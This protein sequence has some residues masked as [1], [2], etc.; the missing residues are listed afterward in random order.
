MF[1]PA[2]FPNN[3]TNWGTS[4]QIC[5]PMKVCFSFKPPPRILGVTLASLSSLPTAQHLRTVFRLLS[6]HIFI[7]FSS[8]NVLPCM[9]VCSLGV[10]LVPV[11][12]RREYQ[13][14]QSTCGW[15]NGSRGSVQEQPVCLTAKP[16]L[17]PLPRLINATSVS[18]VTYITPHL[19]P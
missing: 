14:P 10:C 3:T 16:S 5:E 13:I 15:E 4:I 2:I 1:C 12:V 11:E 9:H 6:F 17:H 19:Y 18:V 7:Y 8:M